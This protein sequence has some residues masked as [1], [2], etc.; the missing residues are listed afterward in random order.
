MNDTRRPLG[1][2]RRRGITTSRSTEDQ[3]IG[4]PSAEPSTYADTPTVP[5]RSILDHTDVVLYTPE[6]AAAM[7][8]V[9]PSW[10]RR[11]A[12]AR[13]VPCRFLG[14]HLRFARDDIDQIAEAAKRTPQTPTRAFTHTGRLSRRA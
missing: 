6:Q 2:L 9:R 3:A 12:A 11:R 8:Q 13:A 7:L 10:L 4:I 5:E 14:K 1:R